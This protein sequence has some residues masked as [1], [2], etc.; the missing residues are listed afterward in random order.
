MRSGICVMNNILFNRSLVDPWL[1]ELNLGFSWRNGRSVLTKCRHSGPFVVQRGFYS[2]E[3]KITPHIYLLHPSGGLVG[4]DKLVLDVELESGSQVLLTTAGASKFY[5]TNGLCA[6]QKNIFKLASNTVLEWVPQSS[7]FFAKSK[8]KI[9]TT[10]FVEKGARVIAFEMLCFNDIT[11]GFDYGPEVVNFFLNINLSDSVGLR[12]RLQLNALDYVIKLGGFKI[13]ALFF[14]VPS[15]KEM[16]YQVRELMNK[17]LIDD[18][19]LIGGATLLGALLVVRLL[20][21][22]NQKLKRLLCYIWSVTRPA[23]LGKEVV[24]PRIWRT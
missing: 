20:G 2:A 9:D 6:L 21:N 4:G 8:V 13:N 19:C 5:R 16:L 18:T 14:A 7:I 10:F 24:I 12:E 3:D 22:D 23:I 11:S 15:N 17:V 1:G